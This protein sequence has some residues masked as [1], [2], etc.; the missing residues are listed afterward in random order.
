M[1]PAR[2]RRVR[3]ALGSAVVLLAGMLSFASPSA[4]YPERV[5][6]APAT[7][8][9]ASRPNDQRLHTGRNPSPPPPSAAPES[10]A[11]GASTWTTPAPVVPTPAPT[12]TAAATA[13][14]VASL[15]APTAS[16]SGTTAVYVTTAGVDSGAG[17]ATSPWRTISYAVA[18]A[19]TGST[20]RIG[21][22]TYAPFN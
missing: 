18:H 5:A 6:D 19:A 11:P 2:T 14:P 22:G 7:G 13:M 20:I 10:T 12:P 9:G 3:L 15:P 4:A 17:T 21:S 8:G 1:P 16:P